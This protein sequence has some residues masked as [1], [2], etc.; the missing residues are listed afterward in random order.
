[1]LK[2]IS[3]RIFGLWHNSATDLYQ[4]AWWVRLLIIFLERLDMIVNVRIAVLLEED[5]E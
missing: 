2:K 4:G 5:D 1:M 3:I